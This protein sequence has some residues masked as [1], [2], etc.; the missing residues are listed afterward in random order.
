M[1][2]LVTARFR[3]MNIYDLMLSLLPAPRMPTL[4][5]QVGT[6][7]HCT[8]QGDEHRR[9]DALSSSG[10]KG[11]NP[12][13]RPWHPY[14]LELEMGGG[15]C[16]GV[17]CDSTPA[18]CGLAQGYW[19]CILHCRRTSGFLPSGSRPLRIQRANTVE[20]SVLFRIACCFFA[21]SVEVVSHRF[22]SGGK[23]AKGHP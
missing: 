11:A 16:C 17:F 12:P 2:L 9:L 23:G 7:G 8:F 19:Q 1:A 3:I 14:G 21:T 22:S 18:S 15:W 5:R 20:S 4:P 6:L 13:A 10:L